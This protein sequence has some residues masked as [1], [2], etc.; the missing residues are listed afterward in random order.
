MLTSFTVCVQIV[1]AKAIIAAIAELT[2]ARRPVYDLRAAVRAEQGERVMLLELAVVQHALVA[3]T[4]AA[5]AAA[6]AHAVLGFYVGMKRR[7]QLQIGILNI[8][9]VVLRVAVQAWL[10]EMTQVGLCA[11]ER[12]HVALMRRIQATTAGQAVVAA[13]LH[14]TCQV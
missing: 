2:G 14:V 9:E 12:L 3:A 4:T 1:V 8:A 7:R 5:A 13:M 6:P 10:T 11:E